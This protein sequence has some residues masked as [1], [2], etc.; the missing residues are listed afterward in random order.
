MQ[1]RRLL[2]RQIELLRH[3]TSAQLLFGETTVSERSRDPVLRGIS[4]PRLQLE[5]EMSY[6]KRMARVARLLR[7]TCSLLGDRR[8]SLFQSFAAACPPQSSVSYQD[9]VLFY[10]F[11]LGQWRSAAPSPSFIVDV[12]KLEMALA[13][14]WLFRAAARRRS[15]PTRSA[16]C[17]EGV[18][19]GLAPGVELLD[20]DYDL[21]ALFENQAAGGT[22]PQRS[23]CLFVA[24][25]PKI[26][27][28][29]RALAYVISQSERSAAPARATEEETRSV[30]V[31]TSLRRFLNA[32]FL[33]VAE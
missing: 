11:L 17:H 29:P 22:P 20:M 16:F 10:E 4:I 8:S 25:G 27:E 12:A 15:S 19:L 33:E 7:R 31:A 21:R 32:G 30:E 23:H 18:W 6:R 13:R 26:A 2:D 28:L 5:A 3:L 24:P 9:A 1:N 14:M